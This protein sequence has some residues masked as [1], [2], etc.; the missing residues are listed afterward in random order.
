[1]FYLAI[2]AEGTKKI[3]VKKVTEELKTPQPFLA[4]LLQQLHRAKLVSPMKGP[5]GR[6]FLNE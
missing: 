5:N 6:F 2:H 4:K 1:M 3:G